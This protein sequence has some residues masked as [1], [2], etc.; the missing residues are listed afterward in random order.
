VP[1]PIGEHQESLAKRLR[2]LRAAGGYSGS[3]FAR[4]LGWQ[5]SRVSK[6]ETG[7]QI[8]TRD[9][10]V[11][12]AAGLD[13][14]ESAR[15]ELIDLAKLAA[16]EYRDWQEEFDKR[17][18]GGGIQRAIRE[19]D[20]ATTVV[21]QLVL[22]VI[23]GLLQTPAYARDVIAAPGGPGKWG[24]SDPAE[25]ERIVG[26]RLA[27]QAL[28]DEPGRKF[29]FVFAETFNEFP[30]LQKRNTFTIDDA[31]KAMGEVVSGAS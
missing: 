28:L 8:A 3:G 26:E 31:L 2:A 30:A 4:H 14:D 27:R 5:Q 19:R 9:D 12:W 15:R 13:L 11:A 23:P 29:H 16:S 6:L 21:R 17:G 20:R 1:R 25:L 18:S 7:F 10:V 22:G 24:A